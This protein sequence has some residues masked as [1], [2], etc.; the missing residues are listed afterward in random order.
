MTLHMYTMLVD[1][2][3]NSVSRPYP[4]MASAGTDR[5]KPQFRA[6]QGPVAAKLQLDKRDRPLAKTWSRDFSKDEKDNY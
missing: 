3:A 6:S 2:W 5:A 1:F 4:F